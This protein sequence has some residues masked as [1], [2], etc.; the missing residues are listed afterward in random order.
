VVHQTSNA[1]VNYSQL[2]GLRA[3]PN[4][5]TPNVLGL[6]PEIARGGVLWMFAASCEFSPVYG[7]LIMT[8]ELSGAWW[9]HTTHFFSLSLLTINAHTL[10]LALP[11]HDTIF[12]DPTFM[13][14]PD[15]TFRTN[16]PPSWVS[17]QNMFGIQAP[18]G[19]RANYKIVPIPNH[20]SFMGLPFS[21]QSYRLQDTVL[22]PTLFASDEIVFAIS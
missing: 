5:V 22:G 11:G 1:P 16:V 7:G 17:T 19:Y 2:L 9:F 14:P 15:L 18:V 12:S 8:E 13:V 4:D 21:A 10:P 6:G 20:P 3:D